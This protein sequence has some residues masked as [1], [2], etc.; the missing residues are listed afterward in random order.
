MTERVTGLEQD[1]NHRFL[2]V[3]STLRRIGQTRDYILIWHGVWL[4][5]IVMMMK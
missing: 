2:T 5:I 3:I 4:L 1:E